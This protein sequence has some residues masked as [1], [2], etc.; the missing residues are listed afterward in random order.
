VNGASRPG[1]RPEA[2]RALGLQIAI[3]NAGTSREIYMR[4]MRIVDESGRRITG[5]GTRV[6]G[7]TDARNESRLGA[8]AVYIEPEAVQF[9]VG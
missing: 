5:F 3:L 1:A 7:N 9:Q 2:A 8:H 4:E 6:L